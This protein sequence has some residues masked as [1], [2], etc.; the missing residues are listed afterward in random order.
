MQDRPQKGLREKS[1]H[2]YIILFWIGS[3]REEIYHP[4]RERAS[5][6]QRL[7][8]DEFLLYIYNITKNCS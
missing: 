3:E 1:L 5:S 2:Y 8:S 4:G 7:K 6:C